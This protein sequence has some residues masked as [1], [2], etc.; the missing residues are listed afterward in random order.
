MKKVKIDEAPIDN[1]SIANPNDSDAVT[2]VLLLEKVTIS[3]EVRSGNFKKPH[4][5]P[6]KPHYP[7][8]V[9]EIFTTDPDVALS[10][11]R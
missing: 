1:A 8:H 6:S 10:V 2:L 9:Q 3:L 4:H 5:S 7:P 11:R